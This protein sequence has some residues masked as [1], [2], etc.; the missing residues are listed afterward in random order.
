MN[1]NHQHHPPR[2]G[3]W[4]LRQCLRIED[5]NHRLG[6]FEE[7][8][9]H[10]AETE[11][12]HIA[13]RLYL[14]QVIRCI[15]EF[16]KNGLYWRY[17]MFKNYV[18]MGIRSL[19]KYWGYTTINISGLAIGLACCVFIF[20]WVRDELSF[21]HFHDKADRIY[22]VATN[23]ERVDQPENKTAYTPVNLGLAL[24]NDY[25]SVQKA[26]RMKYR[27]LYVHKENR[28]FYES[29]FVFA[30]SDFLYLFS[31]P[32]K[33]GEMETALNEPY[34]LI[35]T[36][37][38][39]KKYFGNEDPLGKTLMVEQSHP[40]KITGIIEKIPS[41]S[42]FQF[43]FVASLETLRPMNMWPSY[44][45]WSVDWYTYVL[46]A[47]NANMKSL[48]TQLDRLS[49]QYIGAQED[50]HGIRQR[51]FLQPLKSIYL[52]SNL[53]HEIRKTGNSS[54][55][56]SFV[57]IGVLILMIAGINFV[58]LATARSIK[59]AREVG[60]RKVLGGHRNQIIRQFLTESLMIGFIALLFAVVLIQLL[61]PL[62]NQLSGKDLAFGLFHDTSLFCGL[63]LMTIIVGLAAGTYP[64]LFLS[65][66]Q[67]VNMLKEVNISGGRTLWMR[68]G[69]VIFQFAASFILI[70]G[71]MIVYQ[72]LAF[73]MNK[74]LGFDTEQVLVIPT[75]GNQSLTV[76][77]ES[78][79]NE[80]TRL[81]D[82]NRVSASGTVPGEE[83]PQIV[84]YLEDEGSEKTRTIHTYTVDHDFVETF[85]MDLVAGRSFSKGFST[86][87]SQSFVI[88]EAA[89]K[90]FGWKSP[91]A[92]I[93]KKLTW[94]W[95]GKKGSVIGVVKNF[96]YASVQNSI[97]PLIMHIQPSWYK[98][99]S[100]RV[101][102]DEIQRTMVS[103][104]KIWK[105]FE[106]NYPFEFFF[107]DGHFNRHYQ[108]ELHLGR[109]LR[110]FSFLAILI[111]CLG[112]FGLAAFLA[113]Q[114][115]KEI[116]VRKVLG[117]SIPNIIGLLAKDF[118]K[119]V[120][121]AGVLASPLIYFA[122]T[123]WI[124]NFAYRIHISIW[125]FLSGMLISLLIA[126]FTVSYHSLKAAMSNPVE[127]LK[128][129]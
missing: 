92:S 71:T 64:A 20:L 32:L 125:I 128:Y 58:N 40:F 65:R 120:F 88:N 28:K 53:R 68:K 70:V 18:K 83:T 119:L 3:Q 84:F 12:V 67:P 61:L 62:F 86:D 123:R 82:V 47:N 57:V 105:Q 2:L 4:L 102:S 37:S 109:L 21:D 63:F 59:R 79:K 46:L 117:A 16:I 19:S 73:M 66:F 9:Q 111:A 129:E 85:E 7:V 118:L 24:L 17:T 15:P 44:E 108:S 54:T 81:P 75:Y 51:Y 121:V 96:H 10:I 80:L 52:N 43:D 60:L 110:T 116:G 48:D 107:L 55:V 78:F 87:P 22:R 106:P 5:S 1:F 69:L 30:D 101:K 74:D 126:F 94:G 26:V 25:P 90:S 98:Y 113:E 72:Q 41:N 13:W 35:V 31:F 104:E 14:W 103:I 50:E 127:S 39:A 97:E 27:R 95:P 8:F 77:Y 91:D 42:H 76:S 89:V 56:I 99:F 112:L 33:S 115:T 11:G 34:S 114:R 122:M 100:L 29:R 36:Q 93:S 124:Q 45:W 23:L 6:D 38:M 49:R